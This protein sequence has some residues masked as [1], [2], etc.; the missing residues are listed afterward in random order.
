MASTSGVGSVGPASCCET[1]KPHTIRELCLAQQITYPCIQLCCHYCYKILS[2][3]DIYAF[4]QSC[5]YLSWGEGGPTGICS[6]CTRVLARL[7]FTARHE[8]S[9]AASRLPHFIGQSLSDLE[10]R[11]VRC[12]ALLQSVEKDYILREDLSVHRIGGIWRGTCV[13]CMVGLY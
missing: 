11:C 13:R 6:Q 5:L 1:Q 12:L 2:V 8:V 10:V 7:E 3:L 9:C 4:D